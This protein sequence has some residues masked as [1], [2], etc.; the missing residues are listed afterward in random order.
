MG[1]VIGLVRVPPA[2]N[3]ELKPLPN[4]ACYWCLQDIEGRVIWVRRLYA[5]HP[6]R[7][8][9]ETRALMRDTKET[10]PNGG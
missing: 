4:P 2:Y 6:G 8:T 1:D 5:C 7:C 9:K 10:Q 3:R